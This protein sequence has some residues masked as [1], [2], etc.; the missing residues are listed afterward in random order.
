MLLE[1]RGGRQPNPFRSSGR[2]G[3]GRS[4][5]GGGRGGGMPPGFQFH[6]GWRIKEEMGL[7]KHRRIEI[8]ME[9]SVLFF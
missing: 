8:F 5:G 7:N 1:F 2:G 4:S 9:L 6:Y 3:G